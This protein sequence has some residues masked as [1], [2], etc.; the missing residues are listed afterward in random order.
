MTNNIHFNTPRLKAQLLDES[1]KHH[2]FDLY[3]NP[4]NIEFLHG[5]DAAQ[6][7]ELSIKCSAAYSNIGAYLIFEN[8]SNEFVGVGGIQKQEP[9]WDG[10][11]AMA[12]YDIEF[13]IIL[14]HEFKGQG[15]ASEFCRGFFEMFFSNFPQIEVPARVAYDNSSCIKLLKKFG[16]LESGETHYNVYENKF[17]LLRNSF[18]S[19]QQTIKNP[20]KS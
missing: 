20:L 19:W 17:A 8:H 15:Y 2:V 5:I 10:S 7:I 13:L 3:N 1:N 4:Q 14:S 18:S 11:F 6:D 12:D 9:M 16:F